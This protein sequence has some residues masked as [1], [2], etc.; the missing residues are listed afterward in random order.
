MLAH[1]L[2]PPHTKALF[3]PPQQLNVGW[4]KA[5]LS[6]R[7][8]LQI[9]FSIRFYGEICTAIYGG[10]RTENHILAECVRWPHMAGRGRAIFSQGKTRCL[11]DNKHL[12]ALHIHKSSHLHTGVCVDLL[13]GPCVSRLQGNDQS[14]E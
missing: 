6:T 10:V 5:L 13:V 4:T 8:T 12:D 7:C 2:F 11:L 1:T 9:G 14:V 3:T